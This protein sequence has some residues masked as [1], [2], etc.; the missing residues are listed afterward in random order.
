MLITSAGFIGLVSGCMRIFKGAEIK[1]K[2]KV[3]IDNV[4]SIS[5]QNEKHILRTV[6]SKGEMK[7]ITA[8]QLTNIN[9]EY[10][11]IFTYT[12]LDRNG[13]IANMYNTMVEHESKNIKPKLYYSSDAQHILD[14]YVE[15][16][17]KIESCVVKIKE[18]EPSGLMYLYGIRKD[19]GGVGKFEF[20][21]AYDDLDK[22]IE[23]IVIPDKN[24]CDKL[25][26]IIFCC[27]FIFFICW[28]LANLA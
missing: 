7:N 20:D 28:L 21:Y 4:S 14:K 15:K 23:D 22:L 1:D 19:I 10:E 13:L 27:I 5:S 2:K 9:D 17:I 8:W 6:I 18:S 16:P 3:L 11:K 12:K 25:D 26:I 24:T